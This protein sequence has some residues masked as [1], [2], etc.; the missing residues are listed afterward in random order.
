MRIERYRV[1]IVEDDPAQ[2]AIVSNL[3]YA[4]KDDFEV[5]GTASDIL[6]ARQLLEESAPDLV[7]LDVVLPPNDCFELLLSLKSI[8]FKIIFTT[9]HDAFAVRA[10]RVSAID[11]L[12]KPLDPSEFQLAIEKFKSRKEV[13][14][15]SARIQNMLSNFHAMEAD[16]ARVALPTL[17]GFLYL[18]IRDVVRCESDNTYT[19]FFT[20]DKKKFIVSRTMK[21]CEL[22]LHEFGFFR[23][24]NSHLINLKYVVEYIK[25]EGGLVRM[26]DGSTVDVSRRRKEE[27]LLQLNTL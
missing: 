14:E 17:N 16:H 4:F 3:L 13:E 22:L 25:G 26:A 15:G 24:H 8:P 23:V 2:Q 5:V 20:V 21:E 18:P 11:Y 9:S 12:L 19:S 6:T 1:A 7:I 10:F 27:F